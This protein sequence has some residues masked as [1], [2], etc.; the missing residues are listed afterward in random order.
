LIGWQ[1]RRAARQHPP[2]RLVGANS[3]SESELA[4]IAS[5]DSSVAAQVIAE[6]AKRPFSN[7]ADLVNRITGLSSAQTAFHASVS[8]LTVDGNSLAGALPDP[9]MAAR[10]QARFQ[11]A[12]H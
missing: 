8:G 2:V 12:R 7:W 9:V 5:A 6:R 1:Q 4:A 3:A 10:L 11:G